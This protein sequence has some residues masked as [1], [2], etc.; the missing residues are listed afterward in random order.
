MPV[1]VRALARS[2]SR[3]TCTP[4]SPVVHIPIRLGPNKRV[5]VRLPV[6]CDTYSHGRTIVTTVM[7]INTTYPGQLSMHEHL[8]SRKMKRFRGE[9]VFK[10]HRWLYHSTVGS[11]VIKKKKNKPASLREDLIKSLRVHIPKSLQVPRVVAR[12]PRPST[13]LRLLL[14]ACALVCERDLCRPV[15]VCNPADFPVR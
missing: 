8:L 4:A 2:R 11:S 9:L 13:R 14:A 5:L 1:W 3:S 12:P 6:S 10:A 7:P 15:G